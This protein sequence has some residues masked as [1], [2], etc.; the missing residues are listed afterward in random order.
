MFG[1][2]LQYACLLLLFGMWLIVE[3]ISVVIDVADAL[4]IIVAGFLGGIG[5]GLAN[6][7]V[8]YYWET[9]IKHRMGK[10]DGVG[11]EVVKTGFWWV[12]KLKENKK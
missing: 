12:D 6:K 2:L 10:L 8:E 4:T 9:R 3:R 7:I 5:M 11:K 1:G